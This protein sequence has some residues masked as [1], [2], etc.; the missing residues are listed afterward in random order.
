ME[1][2]FRDLLSRDTEQAIVFQKNCLRLLAIA[3]GEIKSDYQ[4]LLLINGRPARD[5][6]EED[7]PP[8]A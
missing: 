4:K 1:T 3:R 6:R 2:G 8:A 7:L 5:F